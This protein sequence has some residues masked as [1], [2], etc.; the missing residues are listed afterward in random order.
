MERDPTVLVIGEDVGRAGGVFRA[1]AGFSIASAPTAASTCRSLRPGSSVV[2]SV[3]AWPAGARLRDAVRRLL[4]PVPRPADHARRALPLADT[5]RDE[6]PARDPHALRRRR[7]R[8]GAARRLAGDVL[9][10]HARR[11]GGD[12]V[13]AGRCEGPARR[14]DPRPRPGRDPR[15]EAHLPHGAR[16]GA[17]GRARRPAREGADRP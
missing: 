12:P 9:R 5:G 16:R 13:D 1:T 14:G 4:L 15:A 2:Q 7:P 10:A 11:E 17:R 3:S 8:A 6:L